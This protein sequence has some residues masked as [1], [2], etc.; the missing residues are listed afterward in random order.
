MLLSKMGKAN[1]SIYFF[2][3]AIELDPKLKPAYLNR[4]IALTTIGAFQEALNNFNYLI[5]E[6]DYKTTKVYIHRAAVYE[7]MKDYKK[8][9]SDCDTAI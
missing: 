2:N 7:C 8:C 3:K 1:E 6:L 9:L 5:D 4:G